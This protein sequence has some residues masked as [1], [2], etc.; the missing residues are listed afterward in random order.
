MTLDLRGQVW[1]GEAPRG[2]PFGTWL[3]YQFHRRDEVG[4]LAKR[5]RF[6]RDWPSLAAKPSDVAPAVD[7]DPEV[8]SRAYT[9]FV[10]ERTRPVAQRNWYVS[11]L[12]SNVKGDL[13]VALSPLTLVVGPNGSHKSGLVAALALPLVGAAE[14]VG[15][16]GLALMELAPLGSKTLY[17]EATLHLDDGGA[18]AL[19]FEVSGTTAKASAPSRTPQVVGGVGVDGLAAC[20]ADE[21]RALFHAEPKRQREAILSIVAPDSVEALVRQEVPGAYLEAFDALLLEVRAETDAERMVLLAEL[22]RAT[23]RE[24]NAAARKAPETPRPAA[25]TDDDISRLVARAQEVRGRQ[26]RRAAIEAARVRREA[27]AREGE[28]ARAEVVAIGVHAARAARQAAA[29]SA[30]VLARARASLAAW[31]VLLDLVVESVAR[32]DSMCFCC[33]RAITP[34]ELRIAMGAYEERLVRVGAA[35]TARAQDAAVGEAERRLTDAKARADRLHADFEAVGV[36]AREDPPAREDVAPLD[37]AVA[38][39][40]RLQAEQRAWDAVRAAGEA[41]GARVDVYKAIEKGVGRALARGLVESVEAFER[42]ATAM[43]GETGWAV[44]VQVYDGRRVDCRVGLELPDVGF[45][46][47][48]ALSGAQRA[49]LVAAFA[50]AWAK[51]R[52]EPVRLVVVDDVWLDGASLVSLCSGMAQARAA[53]GPSQVVVCAVE[54]GA[55][56]LSRVESLGWGV[57]RV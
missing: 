38:D 30:E 51:R 42:D 56:T 11:R 8:L 23:V 35:A 26:E 39:A 29:P 45:R 5:I 28:T 33:R 24:L 17:A 37:A 53:G 34:E 25:P 10:Q 7:V 22:V 57:V 36:L 43:L 48:R 20:L 14:D 18:E 47:W 46:S 4:E 13:D 6:M 3:R 31:K 21:A 32:D 49:Q 15:K 19:R 9:T 40:R 41:A 54:V 55:E 2:A 44:R 1:R 50:A 12:R 52:L 27:L 16:K